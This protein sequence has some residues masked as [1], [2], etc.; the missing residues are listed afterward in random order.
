[1]TITA[2]VNW[3]PPTE[4]ETGTYAVMTIH[5]NDGVV[6]RSAMLPAEQ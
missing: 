6:E 4:I 5:T 2:N 3:V 1:L